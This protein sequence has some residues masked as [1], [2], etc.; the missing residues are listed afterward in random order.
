[1]TREIDPQAIED[2]TLTWEEYEYLRVR[3]KL[4]ADY[5]EMEPPEDDGDEEEAEYKPSKVVPLDEQ[6]V[7]EMLEDDD[8]SA[9]D[10]AEYMPSKV[11]PLEEQSVPVMGNKGG[12]VEDSGELEGV[13]SDY[14]NEEGWNNDK[15][16]AELA[17]R[18]LVVTGNKE[19]MIGRL[20]RYDA[21]ELYEDDLEDEEETE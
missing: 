9:E 19:E 7:P 1:M 12:I 21:D 18:G 11:I 6:T 15:R 3:G 20:R 8:T 16:R 13:G 17:K 2:E 4:P 10:R 14:S 5:P